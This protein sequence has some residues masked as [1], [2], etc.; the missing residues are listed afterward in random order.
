MRKIGP[1]LIS[2]DHRPHIPREMFS[3]IDDEYDRLQKEGR[4][5]VLGT[6]PAR[7]GTM[8]LCNI[9]DEHENATGITER[10]FEAEAFFRYVNFNQLPIDTSGVITLIKYGIIQ[11]WKKKGDLSLV[12]SPFFSHGMTELI[13]TLKP[14]EVMFAI[15]DPRFTVQSIYN[16]GFFKHYYIHKNRD[17]ALGFQP[18]FPESWSYLFGRLVPTKAMCPEWESL[19][20]IGKISWWGN[21]MITDIYEQLKDL[22][23]EKLFIFSLKEADRDYYAYYTKI[24]ERYQLKPILS[25]EKITAMRKKMFLK[26]HNVVHE[27]GEQ[28]EREFEKY[29]KEWQVLYE[30]LCP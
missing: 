12:Y 23:S 7:S 22:P 6:L 4:R 10:Y 13:Q 24:A 18:A 1:F 15:H 3:Q 8:L 16:K 29:T 11:D 2:R 20:Q 26:K 19:T 17:L 25:E 21:R 28:E 27:W 30:K 9:F 14:N 5:L